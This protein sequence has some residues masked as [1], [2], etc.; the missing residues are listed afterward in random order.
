[1]VEGSGD[2][3]TSPGHPCCL[4]RCGRVCR[5][6]W[7]AA[8]RGQR[9]RGAGFCHS[10]SGPGPRGSGR[11]PPPGPT[12]RQEPIFRTACRPLP[13]CLAISRLSVSRPRFVPRGPLVT[14]GTAAFRRS[15]LARTSPVTSR[16]V[17]EWRWRCRPAMALRLS[18]LDCQRCA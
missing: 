5:C 10:A 11:H 12:R 7:S 14:P 15:Q 6:R 4:R 13:W 17:A 3:A 18:I 1:M 2:H 9:P 16:G 8:I